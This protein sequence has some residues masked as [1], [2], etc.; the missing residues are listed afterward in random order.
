MAEDTTTRNEKNSAS[1]VTPVLF[2]ASTDTHDT[3][4]VASDPGAMRRSPF[5]PDATAAGAT[6]E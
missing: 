2:S 6:G 5:G 1:G 4:M 3:A